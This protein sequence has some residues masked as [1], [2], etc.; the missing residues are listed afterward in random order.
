MLLAEAGG[1]DAEWDVF[2]PCRLLQ[3]FQRTARVIIC[4]NRG[5]HLL[6]LAK[7]LKK[8]GKKGDSEKNRRKGGEFEE[9]GKKLPKRETATVLIPKTGQKC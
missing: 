1:S 9:K 8:R 7:S 5:R 6:R 2:R 4:S 3:K